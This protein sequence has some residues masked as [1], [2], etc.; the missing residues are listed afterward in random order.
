M[1]RTPAENWALRARGVS[2]IRKSPLLVRPTHL[3]RASRLPGALNPRTALVHHPP[4]GEAGSGGKVLTLTGNYACPMTGEM[5]KPAKPVFHI[6]SAD[7]H[8][9]EM[10]DPSKGENSKEMEITYTRK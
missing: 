2:A 7:K 1:T 6:I 10:H 3:S 5:H 9:F 4:E 8:V